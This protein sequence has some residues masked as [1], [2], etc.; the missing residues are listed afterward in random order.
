LRTIATLTQRA[1]EAGLSF[2]VIG[3][4]AVAAHGFS[5]A[6]TDLDIITDKAQRAGWVALLAGL[7]YKQSQDGGSF[8]QFTA[9]EPDQWDVD[10]LLTDEATFTK[11]RSAAAKAVIAETVV[12]VPALDHLLA[13]KLH[14]LKNGNAARFLKDLEDIIN[15]I[16]AN[17]VDVQGASF[18]QLMEKF[19]TPELYEKITRLSE[20]S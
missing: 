13:L 9:P 1:V 18:K 10:V 7:G 20:R 6:T 14:A 16:V 2:V 8:L 3:A 11:F 19:G 4:H 5:R 15:L 17:K 12:W